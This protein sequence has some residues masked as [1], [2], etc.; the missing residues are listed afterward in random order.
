MK[1]SKRWEVRGMFKTIRDAEVL[2][3]RRTHPDAQ[4]WAYVELN[5]SEP[6]FYVAVIQRHNN[7]SYR[8]FVFVS[9]IPL[10]RNLLSNST[11]S[12][13]IDKIY[14]VSPGFLNGTKDWKMEPLEELWELTGMN[15]GSSTYQFMI[16]GGSIYNST[17]S[18]AEVCAQEPRLLFSATEHLGPK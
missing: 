5:T 16:S 13:W 6:W 18:T 4:F 15:N 1:S 8:D 3:E 11:S 2:P 7:R 9:A 14:L 10:L 12:A 17:I